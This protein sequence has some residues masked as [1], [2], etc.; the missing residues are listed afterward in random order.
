MGKLI[1]ATLLIDDSV[2]YAYQCAVQV[3]NNQKQETSMRSVILFGQYG[4]NEGSHIEH[5]EEVAGFVEKGIVKRA[6]NWTQV[7]ELLEEHR[8]TLLGNDEARAT[9]QHPQFLMDEV[10]L[11]AHMLAL[12]KSGD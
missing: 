8:K 11:R 4:W 5:M 6:S 12:S 2:K 7:G 9:S 1:K 10:A 3:E